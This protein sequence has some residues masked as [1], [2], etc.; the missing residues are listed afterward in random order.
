VPTEA[1][2]ATAVPL[3]VIVEQQMPIADLAV[4]VVLVDQLLQ[5]ITIVGHHGVLPNNVDDLAMEAPT[6]NVKQAKLAMPMLI[7]AQKFLHRK[8]EI[9]TTVGPHGVLPTLSV[10]NL[11]TE[12]LME[13]VHQTKNAGDMS[14]LALLCLRQQYFCRSV[15]LTLKRK[16]FLMLT[17]LLMKIKMSSLATIHKIWVSPELEDLGISGSLSELPC[18]L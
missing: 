2:T 16:Y 18:L 17:Q 1:I 4:K 15:A 14:L 7:L 12:A 9:A 11:A 10:A 8:L 3:P 6:E 13:N 5:I